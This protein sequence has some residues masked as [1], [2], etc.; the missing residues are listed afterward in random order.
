MKGGGKLAVHFV[1]PSGYSQEPAGPQLA[2]LDPVCMNPSSHSTLHLVI[3]LARPVHDTK[4][5]KG[6]TSGGQVTGWHTPCPPLQ[7]ESG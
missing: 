3:V 5:C 4:P 1:C 2:C 7:E 6:A